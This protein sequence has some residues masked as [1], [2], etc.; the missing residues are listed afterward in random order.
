MDIYSLYIKTHKI[1][2]LKYLGQT[3]NDPFKY[4]GSGVDWSIH[5]KQY[6]NDHIT[7]IVFQT[8]DR[9][10]IGIMGRYYSRLW[11]VVKGVDDFGNKI[12]AN[13]IPETGGGDSLLVSISKKGTF[14]WTNGS[15]EKYRKTQPGPDFVRGTCRNR[16]AYAAL[17]SEKAKQMIW[18][19]NGYQDLPIM[20]NDPVPHGYHIGRSFHGTIMN[21]KIWWNNGIREIMAESRPSENFTEGR[22]IL[23]E[24]NGRAKKVQINGIIFGT[25]K[26]AS[27]SLGVSEV[28][29]R[30]YL[31]NNSKLN[32]RIWEAYYISDAS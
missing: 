17:G 5:L 15:I 6:G 2:G 16:S 13:R 27:L 10:Q 1:T 32:D 20:K 31:K 4:T 18:I 22:L 11:N 3:K 30:S 28:T 21:K 24:R 19:S 26:Q 23:N 12:W 14:C 25:I 9:S 7:E 29:V 8:T